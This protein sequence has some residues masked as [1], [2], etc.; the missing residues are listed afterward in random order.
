MTSHILQQ[1]ANV[2]PYSGMV[3]R[4]IKHFITLSETLHF[5]RAS[6]KANI[7]TSALSRNIRRLETELG[8]VL[9]DR[10]NRTV[11]RPLTGPTFQ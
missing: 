8:T 7:S 11:T 6:K 4:T 1:H 5:G 2:P 3:I 9:F 10:D